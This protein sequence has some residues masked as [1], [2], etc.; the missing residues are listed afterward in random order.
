M[1]MR[2]HHEWTEVIREW[3]KTNMTKVDFCKKRNLSIKCF[4]YHFYKGYR[5]NEEKA[6]EKKS[7]A[8]VVSNEKA[9]EKKSFAKVVCKE[10]TPSVSVS[11]SSNGSFYLHLDCG[12]SIEVPDDFNEETLVRLLKLVVKL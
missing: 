10:E 3:E 7:F 9:Q 1:I 5:S 11:P 4:S 8:K 2:S 6:Q 12:R